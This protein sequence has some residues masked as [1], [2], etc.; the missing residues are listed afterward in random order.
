MGGI[1]PG[2]DDP[3]AQL[4]AKTGLAGDKIDDPPGASDLSK[5]HLDENAAPEVEAVIKKKEAI[6]TAQI[7]LE[8][9]A[10]AQ[11]ELDPKEQK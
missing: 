1:A 7:E 3:I 5:S 6:V 10:T 4:N 9:K 11:T 8:A 2:S